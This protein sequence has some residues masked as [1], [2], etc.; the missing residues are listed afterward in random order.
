MSYPTHN[1][2]EL[3]YLHM[4]ESLTVQYRAAKSELARFVTMSRVQLEVVEQLDEMIAR[5]RQEIGQSN[6]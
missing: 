5:K 3:P 4:F 1:P 6:I 2:L